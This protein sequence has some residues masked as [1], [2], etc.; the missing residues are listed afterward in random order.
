M[1]TKTISGRQLRHG[2]P[3]EALSPGE[4]VRVKKRDGKV[5]ELRRVDSGGRDILA[6]LDQILEEIPTT[7]PARSIDL[8]RIVI[9]DRE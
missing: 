3:E 2:A 9:E 7:G 1:P 4:A 6:E 8:A 5:F